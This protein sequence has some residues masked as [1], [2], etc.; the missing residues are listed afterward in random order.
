[1]VVPPIRIDPERVYIMTIS[2]NRKSARFLLVRYA[3]AD[4]CGCRSAQK[5]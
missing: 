5:R 3:G 1:L 4:Q 2:P